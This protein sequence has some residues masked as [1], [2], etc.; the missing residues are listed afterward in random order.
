MSAELNTFALCD[1]TAIG[2][3]SPSPLNMSAPATTAK[4]ANVSFVVAD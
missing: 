4:V 3:P 1:L 2:V